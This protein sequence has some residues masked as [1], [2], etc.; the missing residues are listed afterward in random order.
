MKATNEREL[1]YTFFTDNSIAL[2]SETDL[3][4]NTIYVDELENVLCSSVNNNYAETI[5]LIGNWGS[6]KSSIVKGLEKTLQTKEIKGKKIRFV[7][8]NAWKY[9]NDSFRKTFL[10]NATESECEKKKLEKDLYQKKTTVNFELN[11]NLRFW[12]FLTF[13]VVAIL[14]VIFLIATKDYQTDLEML[15]DL[16]SKILGIAVIESIGSLLLRNIFVETSESIEKEFSPEDFSNR[17]ESVTMKNKKFSIYVIDDLDRCD[18]DQALE[19]L[20]TIKGYLKN[21]SDNGIFIIP[22]DKTRLG[23]ILQSERNYDFTDINEYFSKIFD[24]VIDIKKPGNINLFEM[25]KEMT[26]KSNFKLSNFAISLLCDFLIFTP[27]D[28]KKHLNNLQL[29]TNVMLRQKKEKYIS[30][31]VFKASEFDGLVKIYIIKSRWPEFYEWLIQ[32]Y[33]SVKIDESE[34][35]LEKTKNDMTGFDEIKDFLKVSKSI[36]IKDFSS[37]HHLKD[38][39]VNINEKVLNDILDNNVKEAFENASSNRINIISH[40]EYSFRVHIEQRRLFVQFIIPIT[41]MY[42][43]IANRNDENKSE[44]LAS[45][46][47]LKSILIHFDKR[48][49]QLS[50]TRDYL[51][52]L[53]DLNENLIKYFNDEEVDVNYASSMTRYIDYLVSIKRKEDIYKFLKNENIVKKQVITPSTYSNGLRLLVA[54]EKYDDYNF[55]DFLTTDILKYIGDEEEFIL[56][57]ALEV[58]NFD[59]VNSIIK[60]DKKLSRLYTPDIL[61]VLQVMKKMNSSYNLFTNDSL[62]DDISEVLIINKLFED[63]SDLVNKLLKDTFDKRYIRS[64]FSRISMFTDEKKNTLL[65]ELS[66]LCVNLSSE[67]NNWTLIDECLDSL[68]YSENRLV[69]EHILSL[70]LD[71]EMLN[72]LFMKMINQKF[73]QKVTKDYVLFLNEIENLDFIDNWLKLLEEKGNINTEFSKLNKIINLNYSNFINN[74]LPILI[75]LDYKFMEKLLGKMALNVILEEPYNSYISSLNLGDRLVQ[76]LI[77]K[78][79]TVDQFEVLIGK[80]S[81]KEPRLAAYH[82]ALKN[83]VDNVRNVDQLIDISQLESLELDGTDINYIKKIVDRDYPQ[84]RDK[85]TNIPWK[86]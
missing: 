34:F 2:N 20:D 63:H 30:D 42:F 67:E 7:W 72:E 38:D 84:S 25:I 55:G 66:N 61:D 43:Y 4:G 81:K 85:F 19:I 83:I 29:E 6:G 52:E 8:Y 45:K 47:Q 82:D 18:F 76:V 12:S 13:V 11:K 57:K 75:N 16:T 21:G 44:L 70:S 54:D 68:S 5:A 86:H 3:L 35:L 53:P 9:N 74:I 65:I 27:R 71:P 46:V 77:R 22:V 14:I 31:N 24:V 64:I 59:Y 17:Y 69:V 39:G 10:I 28:I 1:N 78:I 26:E 33:N 73:D 62:A 58:R 49:S 15:I 32:N 79:E 60:L 48:I 23:K 41:N 40:F 80:F 37:Y 36:S 50:D 51:P 56:Q